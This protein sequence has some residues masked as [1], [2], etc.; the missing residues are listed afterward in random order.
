MI[1]EAAF[2]KCKKGVR[3]STAPAAASSRNRPDR[4]AQVAARSPPP[5]SMCTRTSRSR[6]QRAAH[7]CPNVVLTPHLGAS[8]AE[9]Q[10]SVGIEIAEQIADVLNGRRHP[11]RGQHALDR[12][13]DAQ[14]PRAVPR[15]RRQARHPRA[16]D[17]ARA[18]RDSCASP[19][20]ASS[21]TS[22]PTPVTRAI[23]RGFLR[24]ISGDEVNFVNAPVCSSASACGWKSSSPPTRS[25]YT[26][27]IQVEAIAADGSVHAA[28][29]TLIGKRQ[30]AAH[31]RAINGREVEVA[32]E[33]KLLV[34]E[35]HDQPGMVG[36]I[37]TMLGKDKVNIADM[38]LSRLSPAARPTWSST[39][40]HRA[41]RRGAPGDQGPSRDQA[42]EVRPAVA[43]R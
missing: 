14:G 26:E 3:S 32:A 37:G 24:R 35:N 2:E 10:E 15:P 29:G 6:R 22:M 30:P 7:A 12:R 41:E 31:R 40:R 16:A 5:A 34:L 42:G 33:G 27:L 28:S 4:R 19:I 17:R 23:E 43:A 36:T 18:D 9:A 13:R 25:G 8:T 21:S 1:D 38:S 39:G 11:Q 20:G